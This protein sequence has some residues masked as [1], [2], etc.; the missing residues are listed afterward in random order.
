MCSP[1]HLP[2]PLGFLQLF[3][4]L[5]WRAAQ[6]PDPYTQTQQ[7]P[8]TAHRIR[9]WAADIKW[10]QELEPQPVRALWFTW[11]IQSPGAVQGAIPTF[12]PPCLGM[13]FLVNQ[14]SCQCVFIPFCTKTEHMTCKGAADKLLSAA[15]SCF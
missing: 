6:A 8:Y 11:N 3:K 5:R 4:I 2:R 10:P 14:R 12:N 7:V 9:C 13:D 1:L 15:F